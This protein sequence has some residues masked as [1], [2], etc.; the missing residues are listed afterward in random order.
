MKQILAF[1]SVILLAGTIWYY[2][3][4]PLT[5]TLRVAGH[6]FTIELALTSAEKEKGLGFRDV[7]PQDRGMLFVFD[8]K[9]RYPFWMKGMRFPLDILWIDDTTVVDVSENVPVAT[10]GVYPSYQPIKPVNKV[11][12]VN[13]GVV[14]RF[15]IS[16]GDTVEILD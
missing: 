2:R 4:H 9:D 7:L 15:G 1:I 5:P 14:K 12:E 6:T 8:H 11:L 3:V 13:A 16:I 10:V